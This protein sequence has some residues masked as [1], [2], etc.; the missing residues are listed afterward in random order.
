MQTAETNPIPSEEHKKIISCCSMKKNNFRKAVLIANPFDNFSPNN[1]QNQDPTI[2]KIVIQVNKRKSKKKGKSRRFVLSEV[3]SSVNSPEPE[4]QMQQP[5]NASEY[6][7]DNILNQHVPSS[8]N[9]LRRG[10]LPSIS[11]LPFTPVSLF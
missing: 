11:L 5:S 1:I 7:I 6:S 3:P 10:N 4:V 8:F 2:Q 9:I